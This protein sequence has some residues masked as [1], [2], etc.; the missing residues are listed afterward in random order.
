[1]IG[2]AYRSKRS[3]DGST[4]S[5]TTDSIYGLIYIR[6]IE[7]WS[8]AGKRRTAV[9]EETEAGA[10]IQPG[11]TECSYFYRLGYKLRPHRVLAAPVRE[12]GNG[13]QGPDHRQQLVALQPEINP[14]RTLCRSQSMG[15]VR[16]SRASDKPDGSSPLRI[17][18]MM[19]GASVVSFRMRT[20]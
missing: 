3:S 17:A 12:A 15:K 9:L 18:S 6:L 11:T 4:G 14:N 13:R 10:N 8:E 1:M 5:W 19:S 16:I 2:A 20:T 7:K